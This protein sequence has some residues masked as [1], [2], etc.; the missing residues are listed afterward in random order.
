MARASSPCSPKTAVVKTSPPS[1]LSDLQLILVNCRVLPLRQPPDPDGRRT[2]AVA[3]RDFARRQ[4][5]PK[6]II[7][8]DSRPN[9]ELTRQID[10]IR[11]EEARLRDWGSTLNLGGAETGEKDGPNGGVAGTG[12]P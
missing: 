5:W 10:A 3:G 9:S 1:V 11:P 6:K 12:S 7:F 8:H 2:R 4:K